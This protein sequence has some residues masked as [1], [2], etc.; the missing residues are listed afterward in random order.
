MHKIFASYSSVLTKFELVLFDRL[1]YWTTGNVNPESASVF[2]LR[3]N[4]VAPCTATCESPDV[5]G[6]TNADWLSF[7]NI[8]WKSGKGL[9]KLLWPRSQNVFISPFPCAKKHIRH[10]LRWYR[11]KILMFKGVTSGGEVTPYFNRYFSSV[12]QVVSMKLGQC[13]LRLWTH[14]NTHCCN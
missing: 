4:D 2:E 8:C 13:L 5:T 14:V 3:S 10:K 1:L 6:R 11:S 12:C 7:L 9:S